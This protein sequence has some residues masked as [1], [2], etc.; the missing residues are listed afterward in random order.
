MPRLCRHFLSFYEPAFGVKDEQFRQQL[1]VVHY[2]ELVNDPQTMLREIATFTGI[3]F[4][5]IDTDET[6]DPGHVQQ[7]TTTESALYAPWVTEL[8]GKKLSTGRVG[9]YLNV[10]TTTEVAQVEE[11]CVDFFEWFGYRRQA[12]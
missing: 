3:S 2:E 1:A 5:Q 10:L 11:H 12:A 7:E 6:P 8:S 9:N 4:D